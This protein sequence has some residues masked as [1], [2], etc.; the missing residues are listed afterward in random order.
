M[1]EVPA[2]AMSLTRPPILVLLICAL[3]VAAGSRP[4]AEWL[5]REIEAILAQPEYRRGVPL[6]QK[7]LEWI[8]ELLRS[9]WGDEVFALKE[10]WPGLYWG[11]VAL[12]IVALAL[13][14]A[15]ILITIRNAFREGV[16]TRAPAPRGRSAD[17]AQLREQ[18]RRLASAGRLH[19]AVH[20]LFEAVVRQLDRAGALRYD[21]ASTN[22]EYVAALGD[23]P[24]IR[25]ELQELAR[26]LDVVWYGGVPL[27]GD[28]FEECAAKLDRVWELAVEL[29]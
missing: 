7:L 1:T 23:H 17:P 6:I 21:P 19:E 29:G 5:H 3:C 24:T 12:L 11:I 22:W 28:R 26:E 13:L 8:D 25:S 18:A 2:N 9:W 10:A 14:L 20:L 15:H 27:D 4:A 16:V